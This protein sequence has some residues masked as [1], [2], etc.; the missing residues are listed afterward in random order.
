[1]RD[2]GES[3]REI[4]RMAGIAEKAVRELL[5]EAQSPNP[6]SAAPRNAAAAADAPT[7]DKGRPDAVGVH[8]ARADEAAFETAAVR[9]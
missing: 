4:A 6:V 2:R 7:T 3:L 8:P 1:M 9:A 5:R